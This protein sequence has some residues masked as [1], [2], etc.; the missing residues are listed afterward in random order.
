MRAAGRPVQEAPEGLQDKEVRENIAGACGKGGAR[1]IP[2]ALCT[3]GLCGLWPGP[4]VL[5]F[6]RHDR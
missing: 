2:A 3:E 5:S 4:H 6:D 1:F